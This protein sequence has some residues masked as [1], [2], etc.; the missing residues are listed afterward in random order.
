VVSRNSTFVYKGRAVDVKQVAA[1]QGVRYILEGSVR[2]AGNQ[3][4]V[5]AQLIDATSGMHLWADHYNGSLDDVF[6]LQ[7][8]IAAEIVGA[9]EVALTEGAQARLLRRRAGDPRVY[10]HILRGRALYN[11]FTRRSNAQAREELSAAVRRNPEFPTAYVFLGYTHGDDVR[12]GW[13]SD[14][15]QSLRT[16]REM[17]QKALELDPDLPTPW[18]RWHTCISSDAN[19]TKRWRWRRKR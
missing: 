16:L 8:E 3:V 11:H 5:T 17:A 12:W 10:E 6:A 4:R 9:L 15:E 19:M 7:D 18:P 2:K 1:E 13:S 14:P